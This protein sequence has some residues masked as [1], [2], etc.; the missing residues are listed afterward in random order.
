MGV[1]MMAPQCPW[2]AMTEQV[3]GDGPASHR[4][5]TLEA[6]SSMQG[7]RANVQRVFPCA[8][9][10][11]KYITYIF[12]FNVR[13]A[14]ETLVTRVINFFWMVGMEDAKYRNIW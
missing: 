8:S 9:H 6:L 13:L 14:L 2:S 1:Q 3:P 7:Q 12:N 5:V 10:R 4:A 11:V